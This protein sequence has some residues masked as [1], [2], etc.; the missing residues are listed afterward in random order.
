MR[1]HGPVSSG[2]PPPERTAEDEPDLVQLMAEL[3]SADLVSFEVDADGEVEYAL[4]SRGAQAA[5]LM[6][7]SRQPHALALLGALMGTS[8]RRH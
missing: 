7:M 5:L 8:D 1:A 4:T 3:A 2:H 6:A